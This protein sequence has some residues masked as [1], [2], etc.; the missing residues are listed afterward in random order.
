MEHKQ[1]AKELVDRFKGISPAST[2]SVLVKIYALICVDEMKKEN[3]KRGQPIVDL[4]LIE[5]EIK[6]WI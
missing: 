6:S 2:D 3:I 4:K 5:Q 1:K